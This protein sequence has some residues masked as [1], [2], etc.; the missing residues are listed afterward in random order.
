MKK[1]LDLHGITHVN[2]DNL[3][4][5]FILITKPPFTIITGNSLIMKNKSLNLLNKY[6]FKWVI[7]SYNLGEIVVTGF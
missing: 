5:D 1:K 7:M 3:I 6:N 4:E 2:A